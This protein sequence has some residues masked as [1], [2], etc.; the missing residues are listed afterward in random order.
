[1]MDRGPSSPLSMSHLV[2]AAWALIAVI[3]LSAGVVISSW[4]E[5]QTDLDSV[6]RWGHAWL[7]SGSNVYATP[8][9]GLPDY[10]PHAVVTL[11]P[12]GALPE[13]WAVPVWALLNVGMAVLVCGLVVRAM[14]PDAH[15]REHLLPILMFLCWGAFRTLLQFSL[16]TFTFG[17]LTTT[18]ARRRP[19]WS[20]IC[21]GLAL[22]KPQ[23]G[24]PFFLWAVFTHRLRVALVG[25]F[26]VAAGLAIFCLRAQANPTSVTLRYGEILRAYH[27]GE[28]I[29]IG[30]AQLRP[31]IARAVSYD[32][33]RVDALTGAAALLLLGAIGLLGWREQKQNAAVM[34]S[35][36]ALAGVWSLLT[37]YTLT[38]GF[39]LLL[40]AAMVLRS[41]LDPHTAIVRRRVFW[42]LQVAMMLDVPGIAR[43]VEHL[44][45][46]PP[47]FDELLRHFDRWSMLGLFVCLTAMAIERGRRHA[48]RLGAVPRK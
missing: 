44:L 26:V 15:V 35:A 43:H 29:L 22:M 17:L 3:N 40:P 5:R 7:V 37:F 4:P 24:L 12:L 11:S 14:D 41:A 10:P 38:Y 36:P 31:L 42:G 21:L 8:E 20:G 30:I 18:L 16:L 19:A 28:A 13:A 32:L 46:V 45:T 48:A 6:R 27:T 1:M 2:L 25:T 9:L 23:V 39:V 33:A 34:Y 47:P